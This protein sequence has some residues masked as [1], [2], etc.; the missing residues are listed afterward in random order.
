MDDFVEKHRHWVT[1]L[2]GPLLRQGTLQERRP[3][4]WRLRWREWDDELGFQHRSLRVPPEDLPV[5]Q[6]LMQVLKAQREEEQAIRRLKRQE[7]LEEARLYRANRRQIRDE[8]AGGRN[9]KRDA[10]NLYDLFVRN[11]NRVDE[12]VCELVRQH[13]HPRKRGRKKKERLIY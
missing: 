7:A 12:P 9:S 8:A 5:V 2:S 1:L 11:Y 3:L 4:E 10:M 6:E 13:A